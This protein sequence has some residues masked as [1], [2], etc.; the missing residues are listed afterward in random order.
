MNIRYFLDQDQSSHWHLVEERRRQEWNEWCEL[1]LEDEKA[2][3]C[4][5]FA[6][7]IGSCP[8]LVSFENPVEKTVQAV[9]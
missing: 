3:D 9:A 7:P 8:S 5:T 4:P 6:R 2:W 1:D